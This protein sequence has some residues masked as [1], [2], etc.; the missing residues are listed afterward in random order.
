MRFD[1]FA[2][3]RFD[4]RLESCFCRRAAPAVAV[5]VI[6]FG[7][8]RYTRTKTIFDPAFVVEEIYRISFSGLTIVE[9]FC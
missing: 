8:F 5:V 1:K 7:D 4:D 6:T 9:T 2:G 3:I